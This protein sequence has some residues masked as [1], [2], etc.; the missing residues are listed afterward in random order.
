[1]KDDILNLLSGKIF[2]QVNVHFTNGDEKSFT[3]VSD[4]LPYTAN[5]LELST[6]NHRCVINANEIAYIE[7]TEEKVIPKVRY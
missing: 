1:M 4:E 5:L 3:E 6:N 2:H 7:I